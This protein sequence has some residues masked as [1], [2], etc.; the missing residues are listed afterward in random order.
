[1]KPHVRKRDGRWVV[2]RPGYGFNPTSAVE[3][4][5]TWK[6]AMLSLRSAPAT[7]YPSVERGHHTLVSLNQARYPHRGTIRMEDT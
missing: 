3:D 7:S 4:F 1:M 6:A 2:V 5:P